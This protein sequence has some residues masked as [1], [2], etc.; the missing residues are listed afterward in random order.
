M[1]E[2]RAVFSPEISQ[3]SPVKQFCLGDGRS[4][5]NSRAAATTISKVLPWD[6]ANGIPDVSQLQ[7]LGLAKVASCAGDVSRASGFPAPPTI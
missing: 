3:I 6:I 5:A 7:V 4:G 1:S 2:S